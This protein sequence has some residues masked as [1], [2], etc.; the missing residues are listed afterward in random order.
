MS[1]IAENF[2]ITAEK[3]MISASDESDFR[4]CVSRAYYSSFHASDRYH[5]SLAKLG[6]GMADVGSHKNLINQL[7]N[8]NIPSTDKNYLTSKEVGHYLLKMKY[9]REQAD[10]Q[11]DKTVRKSDAEKV[12][13]ETKMLLETINSV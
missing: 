2:L 4:C 9:Q 3:N 13:S 5:N 7:K 8:P 6:S 11:L 12:I 1:I 10:Y